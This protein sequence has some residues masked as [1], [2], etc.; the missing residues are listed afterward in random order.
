MHQGPPVPPTPIAKSR[1][2]RLVL[3]VLR[4][5]ILGH[6]QKVDSQR[7]AGIT[8]SPFALQY[9]LMVDTGRT[10]NGPVKDPHL[11]YF[12]LE[13][14]VKVLED[15]RDA[16]NKA[17]ADKLRGEESDV[18]DRRPVDFIRRYPWEAA[19]SLIGYTFATRAA[20][21][22]PDWTSEPIVQ[23]DD[24]D[25]ASVERNIATV[26]MQTMRKGTKH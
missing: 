2:L 8:E 6:L 14:E 22:F 12:P 9:F 16:L 26:I 10:Y 7:F 1:F 18:V 4:D 21:Y 11:C 13:D 17:I 25:K 15:N 5:Q 24:D 23:A 20:R 3:K 19:R